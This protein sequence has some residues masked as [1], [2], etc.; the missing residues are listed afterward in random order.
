MSMRA[1]RSVLQWAAAAGLS[2]AA[3]LWVAEISY[4]FYVLDFYAPELRAYNLVKSVDSLPAGADILV[5]GDSYSAGKS[6]Y[7]AMLR[8]MLPDC[9]IVNGAI[10]GSGLPQANVLAPTLFTRLH[11]RLFIY[12]I[13][14]GNDLQNIRKSMN[15]STISLVRNL[16][17]MLSDHLRVL[18]FI[19]FRLGQMAAGSAGARRG[20]DATRAVVLFPRTNTPVRPRT[21]Y[22]PTPAS[23]KNRL[24]YG[25]TASRISKRSSGSWM[26]C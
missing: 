18:G 24:L 14:V 23:M 22:A 3:A 13:Y 20:T 1:W 25:G 16:Y 21:I 5:M 11:P 17:W 12:Q 6:S 15:W 8:E 26:I 9:A 4:R 19:N 10:P 7:V 2:I